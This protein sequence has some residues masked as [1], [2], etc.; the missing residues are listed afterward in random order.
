MCSSPTQD[1]YHIC[2]YHMPQLRSRGAIQEMY[3]CLCSKIF[4]VPHELGNCCRSKTFLWKRLRL[5]RS[6]SARANAQY[7]LSKGFHQPSA[8][9]EHVLKIPM[10]MDVLQTIS[11]LHCNDSSDNCT[12]FYLAKSQVIFKIHLLEVKMYP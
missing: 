5:P 2:L 6:P 4:P 12:K 10:A 7:T 11:V 3:D 8:H 1:C 9:L